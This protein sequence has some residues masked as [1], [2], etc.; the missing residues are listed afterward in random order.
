[1]ADLCAPLRLLIRIFLTFLQCFTRNIISPLGFRRTYAPVPKPYFPLNQITRHLRERR[2][3][4]K[5]YELT[6]KQRKIRVGDTEVMVQ[7]IN[8]LK[9]KT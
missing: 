7:Q 1:M 2:K 9:H 3:M 5:K 6:K 8:E 4:A